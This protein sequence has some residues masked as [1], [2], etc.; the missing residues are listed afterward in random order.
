MIFGVELD[1][2]AHAVVGTLFE[3][4]VD[5]RLLCGEG[6]FDLRRL[7]ALLRELDFETV[8]M[9]GTYKIPLGPTPRGKKGAPAQMVKKD[10]RLY[11]A[12]VETPDRGNWFFMLLGP[13]EA[14]QAAKPAFRA[15]LESA[16]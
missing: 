15:M 2:A 1:D 14:V 7:V 12:A 13:D 3:D 6:S 4:T 11:G 5:H 9:R 10:H 8:D 16:R